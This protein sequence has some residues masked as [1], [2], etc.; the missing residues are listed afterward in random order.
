MHAFSGVSFLS[1][2]SLITLVVFLN[3]FCTFSFHIYSYCVDQTLNQKRAREE[4]SAK[5]LTKVNAMN[6]IS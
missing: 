3:C 4:V 5:C 1:V 2:N 6:K